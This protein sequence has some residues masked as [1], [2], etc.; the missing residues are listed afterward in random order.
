MPN[1]SST[2]YKI[3]AVVAAFLAFIISID[4][5]YDSPAPIFIT[6]WVFLIYNWFGAVLYG[7][8][9]NGKILKEISK[10]LGND[11]Q[12]EIVD[13]VVKT[14]PVEDIVEESS[15]EE[16][17]PLTPNEV[18]KDKNSTNP[19]HWLEKKEISKKGIL[20]AIFLPI[21]FVIYLL[22]LLNS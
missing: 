19:D 21:T 1:Y 22:F 16:V 12:D 9:E 18:V 6:V 15:N 5:F 2:L 14:L 4:F 20:I 13:D 3:I 10:K 17:E 7:L 8:E 11:L